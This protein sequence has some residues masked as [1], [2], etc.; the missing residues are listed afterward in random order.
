MNS[1]LI[2]SSLLLNTIA[3]AQTDAQTFVGC[4]PSPIPLITPLQVDENQTVMATI[5]RQGDDVIVTTSHAVPKSSLIYFGLNLG[6]PFLGYEFTYSRLKNGNLHYHL[7]LGGEGSLGGS[8]V[9]LRAG[10]H[11]MGNAFFVGGK[12]NVMSNAQGVNEF[13]LGPT[14]GFSG[15]RRFVTGHIGLSLLADYNPKYQV[16]NPVPELVMGVRLRL[17]RFGK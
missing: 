6:I 12:A 4:D 9:S 17:F 13:L 7:S 16:V 2:L 14:V 3:F 5:C 15:G 11:P 8:A 1:F 10:F